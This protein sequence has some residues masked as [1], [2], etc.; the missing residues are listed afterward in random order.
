M[1]FSLLPLELRWKIWIEYCPELGPQ[2]MVLSVVLDRGG[3]EA[4]PTRSLARTTTRVRCLLS[5]SRDVRAYATKAL[6]NTIALNKG[7]G[8]VRYVAARDIR[9]RTDI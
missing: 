8:I 4:R 9:G 2:P 6:P 1:S 5:L 7:R 3:D